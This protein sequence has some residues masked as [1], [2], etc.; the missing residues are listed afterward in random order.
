[1]EETQKK[2][3]LKL[4]N[5]VHIQT[6]LFVLMVYLKEFNWRKL[7]L[8]KWTFWLFQPIISFQARN[9]SEDKLND[10]PSLEASIDWDNHCWNSFGI[11]WE[12]VFEFRIK[13]PKFYYFGALNLVLNASN[14]T[15]RNSWENFWKR[16]S[17][18]WEFE[19]KISFCTF[20][21]E[22]NSICT[23]WYLLSTF[24]FWCKE[25]SRKQIFWDNFRKQLS[26]KLS[27]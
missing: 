17:I 20:C 14:K 11:F 13:S 22:I 10:I 5:R 9:K 27:L 4:K 8:T 16:K 1:M 12:K 3:Q 23:F 2:L 26:E 6:F 25:E 19:R 15:Q 24:L 7:V 18:Q 21:G